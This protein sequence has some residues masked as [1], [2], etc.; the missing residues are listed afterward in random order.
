MTCLLGSRRKTVTELIASARMSVSAAP[1][2]LT[3]EALEIASAIGAAFK[4]SAEKAKIKARCSILTKDYE[5]IWWTATD[6]AP[7]MLSKIVKSKARSYLDGKTLLSPSAGATMCCHLCPWLCGC[8]NQMAIQGTVGIE[9][10][11]TSAAALVVAGA[12]LGAQDL[13]VAE[14][15]M[16]ACGFAKSSGDVFKKGGAPDSADMER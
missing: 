7:G 10:P 5:E 11:G 6:G 16:A 8:T 3:G 1:P 14:E 15:I 2:P 12:P 13:A 9:L 4:T